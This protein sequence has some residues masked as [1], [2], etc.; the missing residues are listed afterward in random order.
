MIPSYAACVIQPRIRPD[1]R[2]QLQRSVELV[3]NA[4]AFVTAVNAPCRI[5]LFPECF[6]QAAK[7][8]MVKNPTPE[9]RRKRMSERAI[10]V[11]GEEID[12]LA[13][14]AKANRVFLAGHVEGTIPEF[15]ERYFSI[16]FIIGPD[17]KLIY[18]YFKHNTT[19]NGLEITT[20]PQDIY[21]EYVKKFGDK[22]ESFFPTIDTEIGKLG[23]LVCSDGQYPEYA[24]AYGVQ[25]VDILLRP[26]SSSDSSLEEPND[27]WTVSNRAIA[28][29][30][31]CYVMFSNQGGG[32]FMGMDICSGNSIICDYKGRVMSRVTK[33]GETVVHTLFDVEG[34]R[35]SRVAT[36]GHSWLGLRTEIVRKIYEKQFWPKNLWLDGQPM[37]IKE[38]KERNDPAV[39]DLQ[40][41]YN[42]SSE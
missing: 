21:D 30:N 31:S 5:L 32:G 2:E 19:N 8:S 35:R 39:A 17:G 7:G 9:E 36:A 18:R 13:E 6:L 22:L 41:R 40:K 24:R 29:Q 33:G 15:P 34:I 38:L 20:S 11:P 42:I 1:K 10:A 23:M 37:T 14:R 27:I 25:N 12:T 28:L 16:A 26:T 3:D 4:V